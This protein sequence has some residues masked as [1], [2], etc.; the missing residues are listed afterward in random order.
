MNGRVCIVTG[1][2]GG[3]GKAT[4]LGLA[5]HGATVLLACRDR[6]RGEA[7]LTEVRS[8]T[9]NDVAELMLVD[10]S[11]QR[12]IRAMI[13]AFKEKHKQLDVLIN[14][15]AVY[16][17]SR[18]LTIDGAETM[19]ATNHLG[20]FLLTNLLL[21]SLKASPSARII[22]ITAPS[23][24]RLNFDDLQGEQSFSALTT[25]G[26]TKMCNLLFTYEL[27]R[28]L[29][30]TGVAAN[31]FHPGLV[32]SSLMK[33]APRAVRW[34]TQLLSTS[35][36]RAAKAL[37]YLALS[38]E[39]MEMTGKFFKGRRPIESDTYS[40]DQQVQR[41]LWDVSAELVGL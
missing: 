28:R 15:A 21:D 24:T 29:D 6:E 37:V 10:L 13:E 9:G 35:P 39:V 5:R 33:E 12:S 14:N 31:A 30:G 18:T 34:L 19:F 11:S 27:A 17:G 41:R 36:E 1:A 8:A 16:K 22:T 4:A 23:T 32:K 26:A 25:F 7:A 3:L 38:P 40:K 2:N 20:P